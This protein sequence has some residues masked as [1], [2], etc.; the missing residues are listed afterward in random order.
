MKGYIVSSTYK[1]QDDSTFVYLFGTL[2]NKQS[3]CSIHKVTPYCFIKKT[4]A[5]KAQKLLGNATLTD[6][7]NTNFSEEPVSKIELA[8]QTELNKLVKSLHENEIDT[9]EADLKPTMRFMID[10]DLYGSIEFNDKEHYETADKVDRVY[11]NAEV[12]S[13]HYNPKLKIISLDIESDKRG[14][15]LFCIGMSSK[16]YRKC[17]LVS[18]K[19]QTIPDTVICKTEHEALT[20]WKEELTKFD[21]DIITGYHVIDFDLAFLRDKCAE[22]NISFDIGRDNSNARIRVEPGFFKPSTAIISG[23]QV[24]DALYLIKDPFIKEAPSIKTKKFSSLTL[25]NV[26]QQILGEGKLLKGKD[27]HRQI[28]ALF[29]KDQK[30]L[31]EYNLKDCELAYDIVAK[32]KM[33]ELAIERASLT[34]MP[35]NRITASIAALDSLYI[36]AARKKGLVSPTTRYTAKPEH[37]QGGYVMQSEPDLYHNVVVLDF[38]SLYPSIITTFNIDPASF[39]GEK[40]KSK[41]VIVA[42]NGA[43]FKNTQGILPEII[44]K[45]HT[46]REEAKKEK[47]ELSSYAIKIIMNS[48]FGVLASPNCRYFSLAM[49]NA[50]T[51]FGQFLIKQTAAEIE[52]QG[53]RVIYSDTDSV[54]VVTDESEKDALA[55]G[56]KLEKEINAFYNAFVQNEHHRTSRLELEFEKLYKAFMMPPIRGK[57]SASKKRYAGLVL[58]EG[59]ESVEIVGLEAIRGD[60]TDAAKEFQ[61]QLL[62]KIFHKKEF[63]GFIREYVKSIHEGKLDE[64]LVY[65][66]SLTKPLDQYIKTTPP[67]VKAARKLKKL[68]SKIVQYVMTKEGPEPIQQV[69]HSLDYNHYITKQ[70]KPIANTILFFFEKD[71]DEIITTTKQMKLF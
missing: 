71:F 64:K 30:K 11:H 29:K 50:I 16:N 7:T 55:T 63:V 5:K 24:L 43:A 1:V 6:S 3:F 17:F 28:E 31:V 35:L 21:P 38:K 8:S 44:T 65:Q 14:S 4:D 69:K 68:E 25:E 48:F 41:N 33:V 27:R 59:K 39:L 26:S 9:F 61:V 22:H 70:I 42:P 46:A 23:R 66:K 20:L 10:N 60:W 62:D 12:K 32:T 34:G 47:R 67:H 52:K 40:K 36:R 13:T 37:I 18:K 53:Y 19:E 58:K 54:F 49:G 2:E 51:H 45:L 56:A 15:D 57:E